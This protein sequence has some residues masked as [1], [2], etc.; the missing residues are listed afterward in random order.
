MHGYDFKQNW[1]CTTTAVYVHKNANIQEISNMI[2]YVS[3]GG[4]GTVSDR[5]C[6]LPNQIWETYSMSQDRANQ[7]NKSLI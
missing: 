7:G 6:E 3:T 2:S 4:T 5:W 1:N